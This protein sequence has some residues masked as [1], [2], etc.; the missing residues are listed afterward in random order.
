MTCDHLNGG[1]QIHIYSQGGWQTCCLK[2][3][4][5]LPADAP[6]CPQDAGEAAALGFL[7]REQRRFAEAEEAFRKAAERSRD[8]RC[9]YAALLCRLGVVF[10]GDEFQPTF[11]APE[12]P[13]APLAQSPEWQ[14][15]E[16]GS[17]QLSPYVYQ[18]LAA[19]LEQLE[20]ILRCLRERTGRS[21]CDVFL[22]YRRTRANVMQALE[23]C[24]DLKKQGLRVFCA[25][26][27][28]RGKTQEQFEAEVYHALRTAEHLVLLPGDGA[29]ALTPWLRNELERALCPKANRYICSDGHKELP[30]IPG[31]ALSLQE[32][33][34]ILSRAAADC[35]PERLW[36]RALSAL[37]KGDAAAARPLLLR[38]SA[39]RF[40]PA[41]MLLQTLHAEG[42]LL[43]RSD[44]AAAHFR[45]LTAAPDDECRQQVFS[46]LERIEQ[47]LGMPR[48]RALLYI[49]ADVSDA[50][51][52]FSQVLLRPLLTALR[53]DRRLAGA[54]LCLIG[55]DRHARILAE[56][57]PLGQYGLPESVAASLFTLRGDAR[58]QNAYAAKG[59][60]CAA[61]HLLRHPAD[62]RI[63]LLVLLR[64][65]AASDAPAAVP[66]AFAAVSSL[67]R[68]STAEL[69][70][71]DQISG[72]IR[73]LLEALSR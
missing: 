40:Q 60:R 61:D 12:L 11:Y 65:G 66:A 36:A 56:P 54:D 48:R 38:A 42:F 4:E 23:L 15:V 24:R 59:L 18:A 2:C 69:S 1:L 55:Y 47:A 67:F 27:T 13:F 46:A 57:R 31:V 49:A 7:H 10:C 50:G 45:A 6:V 9:R 44:E 29:D 62:G 63:P 37:E 21:A 53:A 25:D 58:E 5:R 41:R 26:V 68:G 52:S 16:A 35:T 30:A 51:L 72:C 64:S 39:A 33:R 17:G 71:P 43:P 19:Q 34:M 3:G 14:A 28:T 73:G 32:I 8:P 20:E 70:S 22:C